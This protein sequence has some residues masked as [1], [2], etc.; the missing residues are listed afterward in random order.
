MLQ[1]FYMLR[2][3]FWWRLARF[4]ESFVQHRKLHFEIVSLQLTL[5]VQCVFQNGIA[6]LYCFCDVGLGPCHRFLPT[7]EYDLGF[8]PDFNG[9]WQSS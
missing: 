4:N 8:S 3:K 1:R 2:P 9:L 6:C 7:V 5:L